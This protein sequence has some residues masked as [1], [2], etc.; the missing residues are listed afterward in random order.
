MALANLKTCC[1]LAA[2]VS[3]PSGRITSMN[4]YTQLDSFI[5]TKMADIPHRVNG[6]MLLIKYDKQRRCGDAACQSSAV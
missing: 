2:F 5:L 4:H 6:G 3:I 1:T